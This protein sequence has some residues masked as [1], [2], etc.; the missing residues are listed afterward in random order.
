MECDCELQAED[1]QLSLASRILLKGDRVQ[2]KGLKYWFRGA[3][4]LFKEACALS[5]RFFGIPFKGTRAV[6]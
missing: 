5:L 4:D 3:R 6:F 1:D 2:F